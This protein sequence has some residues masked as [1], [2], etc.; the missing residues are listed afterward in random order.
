[1]S[2]LI[3]SH[4]FIDD[5]AALPDEKIEEFKW[6]FDRDDLAEFSTL[7]SYDKHDVLKAKLG[8]MGGVHGLAFAL[9]TSL[10]NGVSSEDL[11]ESGVTTRT[12]V[13]GANRIPKRPARGFLQLMWDALQD[14]MLVILIVAG[15]I[16]IPVG[17][18]GDPEGVKHGLKHGWLEGFAVLL[19]VAI[20]TVVTAINDWQKEKQFRDMEDKSADKTI[21]TMRNAEL[22]E[23]QH[24]DVM[25]G[26]IVNIQPGDLIPCD[27]VVFKTDGSPK[28]TEAA[29]TGET[30]EL[31]KT[32]HKNPFVVKGSECVDGEIWII[33]TG[34]GEQTSYGKLMAG[35]MGNR[36]KQREAEERGEV[37]DE[38]AELAKGEPCCPLF[39]GGDDEDD[40]R[41]PL[42]I[43]LDVLASQVGFLG[44]ASAFF[45]FCALT[46][47]F[48]AREESDYFKA[49]FWHV[50]IYMLVVFG[51][52][53]LKAYGYLTAIGLSPAVEEEEPKKTNNQAGD[54]ENPEDEVYDPY[55]PPDDP[56]SD[57]YLLHACAAFVIFICVWVIDMIIGSQ[58][59]SDVLQFFI[60]SI[61]VIVVAVPE[62]LPLAVTI[63][64]AYS[65]K[66]MYFDNNFVRKLAACETMGNAT[67]ICSD[68]TGTLTRNL[69][70]V[71][72][73]YTG[74]TLVQQ[75][76]M[77]DCEN[78]L[79][80]KIGNDLAQLIS[81]SIS[82]NSKAVE[83]DPPPKEAP[84]DPNEFVKWELLV[85][86]QEVL[87]ILLESETN[88]TESAVL[89]WTMQRLGPKDYYKKARVDFS[90]IKVYPFSSA[91][92]MSSVFCNHDKEKDV[93]RL[94]IKGAAER[95]VKCCTHMAMSTGGASQDDCEVV[96]MTPDQQ[97][98][99][100]KVMTNFT[101]R[102]LRCLGLGYREFH[103]DDIDWEKKDEGMQP[104]SDLKIDEK[105]IFLGVVGIKDPVRDEVP[106]AIKKCQKAG[107]VVRMVTGDHLDTAKHIA[108]ECGILTNPNQDC[109]TG[110]DFRK[111][112]RNTPEG[113]EKTAFM[114]RLRVVARSRP[115]DKELM[116]NW[117]KVKHKDV[118]S[119]TG[120]GANDA[121]ALQEADVGL[122]MNIQGTDVA[123]EASDIVIMDDNFAS[124]VK[125]VKW[126]RSVYD[127][128]RKFVQ[129]QLCVNV[130]ALTLSTVAAFVVGFEMPLTAVQ[131]LWVNLI[132]DTLAALALATEMPTD[133][134]LD[135]RPYKRQT[136]LISYSM[137]R[138]IAV[139]SSIQLIIMFIL[140][141]GGE[142]FLDIGSADNHE[143]SE[144]LDSR[145]ERLMTIVFNTFVWFQI[146][147]EINARKVNGEWNVIEGF[148][149]N[150][151]FSAILVLT[152]I[153]QFLM[154]QFGGVLTQCVPLTLEE[155]AFCVVVG[156]ASFPVG[157]FTLWFPADLQQGMADVND[158]WFHIDREFV[159]GY[160][161]HGGD[162]QATIQYT[163][164]A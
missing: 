33:V 104:A 17:I 137:I 36:R 159:E 56:L 79:G 105:I 155:W 37:Y 51:F 20:V 119:V 40:T 50:F 147:N 55:E 148:F 115:D 76:V 161:H 9:H 88:Q 53:Y 142:S 1:M 75:G 78:N 90:N 42:Q 123:K 139:H 124:I 83:R 133:S 156:S 35:L 63:S 102:G 103:R 89:L 65:M 29:L 72:A 30:T 46:L 126:G 21:K 47:N 110:E 44:T 160:Q 120:D 10:K 14:F 4:N 130:V 28:V 80:E 45:I 125:T 87:K 15:V 74:G 86:K 18:T 114:E 91:I 58:W 122:A 2:F 34:V 54:A 116:V 38:E 164:N 149:D 109:I 140:L 71:V 84:E 77:K 70:T 150:T 16:N 73:S 163:N 52:F 121:L 25:V 127:N 59:H 60:L 113:E 99:I 67:T 24:V 98:E 8:E 61:T 153:L 143:D 48:Y 94:H 134:L 136:H 128:I 66:K 23:T 62:G 26:D 117:Y 93:F 96:A 154:V 19:A 146:F 100:Y 112:M 157:Q 162:S 11:T 158:D 144:D 82:V 107:I 97:N 3:H 32:K 118:V 108:K 141:F 132:M 111:Y 85:K 27:G 138:F 6:L 39:C 129:F 57:P 12:N 95:I 151:L 152:A 68:K 41:T 43:K 81:T 22:T 31:K 101:K 7:Y 69:M 131:L 135:R 5:K 106:G 13:F 92:K 64:L 145:N 49:Q